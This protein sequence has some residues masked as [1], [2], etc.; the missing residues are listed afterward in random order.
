MMN[1][2]KNQTM[3]KEY[4]SNFNQENEKIKLKFHHSFRVSRLCKKIAINLG[5][6]M[7][8][9]KL[10]E[11]IGLLHDI[12][13][14]EQ[15]EK[16]NTFNDRTS[17]DHGTLA[18]EILFDQKLIRKFTDDYEYDKIINE[19]ISNHNKEK[20]N[21]SS[22]EKINL[23]SKILR[24]ADKLDILYLISISE[25][26]IK[27]KN[28]NLSPEIKNT[29]VHKTTCNIN[30]IKSDIDRMFFYLCYLYD[31][32]FDYS[33]KI[34]KR[35]KYINKII[36]QVKTND[37]TVLMFLEIIKKDLRDHK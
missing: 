11:L 25:I 19:V 16:Y 17:V 37:K 9:I 28:M 18:T 20:I 23:Y 29:I 1:I 32:N 15:V 21:L 36:K 22:D 30:D 6:S 24:D 12:G 10:L 35:K 27:L 33:I 7:K 4:T 5:L 34:L 26:K 31:I 13:R 2:Y 3:F 8:E 14:F